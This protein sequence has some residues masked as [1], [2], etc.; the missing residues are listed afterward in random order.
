MKP[1]VLLT[2]TCWWHWVPLLG[3]ELAEAGCD[4][5]AVYPERGHPLDAVAAIRQRFVYRHRDPMRA[6]SEAVE[7]V[8]PDLIVPCDDR[9]VLHLQ[10]LHALEEAAGAEGQP[11]D[12]ARLIA[13]SLGDGAGFATAQSRHA[14]ICQARAMGI[15][16]PATGALGSA[17]DV[18]AWL[19]THDLP[20][21]FKIDGSWGGDGVIVV[22]SREAAH[23]AFALLSLPATIWFALERY[24]I[25]RD[26]YWLAEWR[27]QPARRVSAQSY[28]E[29]RPANVAVFCWQGQVLAGIS[30]EVL[31]T[32]YRHGPAM[33]VQRVDRPEMLRAARVLAAGLGMS[34]FFGLD[35][36][37]D[38]RSQVAHLIEMNARP[39]PA[40]H[41][42]LGAGCDLI[43]ALVGQLSGQA[44][45]P[46]CVTGADVIAYFPEAAR[47]GAEGGAILAQ[48][49]LDIP[50]AA[51][52]LAAELLRRP[53]PTRSLLAR[54]WIFAGRCV[55]WEAGSTWWAAWRGSLRSRKE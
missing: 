23:A 46:R 1:V 34:G 7:R 9:A 42:R 24:F 15:A 39:T 41:L 44:V 30:L 45:S 49:Y 31:H 22:H 5:S 50:G 36:M 19:S 13:V 43:G 6:L 48:A 10:Q 40:C 53:W 28:I 8:R 51:P 37:I 27:R 2:S 25:N 20:S 16:A 35:F 54:G 12:L 52:A 32:R 38:P 26:R 11:S 21:V 3:L 55:R 47:A 17:A 14:L 18:D 33:V 4:V 29:G